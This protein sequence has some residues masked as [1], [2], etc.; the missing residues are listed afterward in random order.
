MFITISN[1]VG[2]W[3]VGVLLSVGFFLALRDK[4][5]KSTISLGVG[6]VSQLYTYNGLKTEY[7]KGFG[8]EGNNV[9]GFYESICGE[10]YLTKS[11]IRQIVGEWDTN[12]LVYNMHNGHEY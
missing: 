4:T 7:E 8:Y 12:L 6:M 5:L 1:M 9:N 11:E 10:A 2:L 3:I